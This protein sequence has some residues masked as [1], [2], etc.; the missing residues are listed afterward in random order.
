MVFRKVLGYLVSGKQLPRR[1]Q[2]G[3]K[4][5]F[6]FEEPNKCQVD[7]TW[8]RVKIERFIRAVTFEP[9]SKPWLK[10]GDRIYEIIPRE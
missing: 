5:Y 9:I 8:D 6:Q 1:K 7:L 10:I 2:E 3:E 4:S